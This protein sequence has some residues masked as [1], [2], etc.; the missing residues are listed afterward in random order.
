MKKKTH[1]QNNWTYIRIRPSTAK[2]LKMIKL[3][4]DIELYEDVL[5]LLLSKYKFQGIKK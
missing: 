1:K 2:K 4:M 3:E 5:D